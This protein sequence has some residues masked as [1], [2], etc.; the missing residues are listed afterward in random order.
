MEAHNNQLPLAAEPLEER[1]VLRRPETETFPKGPLSPC[2]QSSLPSI[3][4]VGPRME[5]LI[6]RNFLTNIRAGSSKSV[7]HNVPHEDPQGFTKVVVQLDTS[8][9][10]RVGSPTYRCR[11]AHAAVPRVC[12]NMGK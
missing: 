9:E 12:R 3:L 6:A 8:T 11:P 10:P 4:T 1:V 2:A 5:R 7:G